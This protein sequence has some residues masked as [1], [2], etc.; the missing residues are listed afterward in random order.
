MLNGCII[1]YYNIV[2]SLH[3][4]FCAPVLN[5]FSR[6]KYSNQNFKNEK[7]HFDGL[8]KINSQATVLQ[9]QA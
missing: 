2:Q 9:A 4:K 6:Y 5:V 1:L 7:I 8:L 3:I